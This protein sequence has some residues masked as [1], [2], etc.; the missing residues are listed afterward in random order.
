LAREIAQLPELFLLRDLRSHQTP[1][2]ISGPRRSPSAHAPAPGVPK[3]DIAIA[4]RTAETL[5]AQAAPVARRAAADT[6]PALPSVETQPPSAQRRR[7]AD[8]LVGE[9]TSSESDVRLLG[10]L[11]QRLEAALVAPAGSAGALDALASHARDALAASSGGFV[12]NVAP[13]G[14]FAGQHALWEPAEACAHVP[15]RL[16]RDGV[17]SFGLLPGAPRHELARFV[18]ILAQPAALGSSEDDSVT[19]LHEAGFEHLV[20]RAIEPRGALSGSRRQHA[21]RERQETFALASFDTSAQLED[22]WYESHKGTTPE[23]AEPVL[24]APRDHDDS[25]LRELA[26]RFESEAKPAWQRVL[27]A[28]VAGLSVPFAQRAV[29]SHLRAAREALA[30]SSPAERLKEG[31][32]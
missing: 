12:W 31:A 25:A 24:A 18:E 16:Y 17:R 11:F 2:P 22:C 27:N 30:A 13:W 26:T 4:F 9:A 32:S 8:V 23:R 3:A 19:L 5:P 14:F 1:S 21:I 15:Y 6:I 28:C 7:V 20:F 29:E 10:E